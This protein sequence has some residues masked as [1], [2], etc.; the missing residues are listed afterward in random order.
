MPIM[1]FSYGP[2]N[3]SQAS[4]KIIRH[5]IELHAK[6]WPS[7][8]KPLVERAVTTGKPIWSPLFYVFPE[9][10]E[11]YEISDEFMVGETL[12]VA[13]VLRPG[14]RAR[15]VYLPPG[16][17]RNFWSGETANGGKTIRAVP[18]PLER[19]PVFERLDRVAEGRR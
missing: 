14:E 18:A 8:F 1:Q 3:Y 4:Q 7:H 17:W 10:E 6:L 2:W 9:D 5:F 15:D 12:L 16:T 11:A 13:P 19:I